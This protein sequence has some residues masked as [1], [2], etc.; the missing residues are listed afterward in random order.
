MDIFTAIKRNDTAF[1][2]EQIKSRA[3]LNVKDSNGMTP[4]LVAIDNENLTIV[5]LLLRA[6]VILDEVDKY[7]QTAL[8]LAAGRG[9]IQVVKLL[10][11]SHANTR[12]RSLSKATAFDFAN[13]NGHKEVAALLK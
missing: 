3:N 8:M 5:R 7:G 12:L 4:L 1:V 11:G 9:N 10:L 2:T 6:K 13:E